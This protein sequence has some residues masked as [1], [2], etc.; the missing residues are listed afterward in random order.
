MAL[1][2]GG[3]E[4]PRAVGGLV[5]PCGVAGDQPGFHGL[6]RRRVQRGQALLAALAADDQPGRI[7]AHRLQPQAQQF[8]HPKTRRIGQL[9]QGHEPQAGGALVRRRGEQS[10]D[11][12]AR[13]GPGQ[14]AALF[15]SIQSPRRIVAAPAFAQCEPVELAH[16]RPP[17]GLG[18]RRQALA[19]QPGVPAF[20]PRL[21][22]LHQP[23]LNA[24]LGVG[25]IAAVGGK[26]MGRG[27]AF[28]GHHLQKGFDLGRAHASRRFL[29]AALGVE[30]EP[31]MPCL[32]TP[33]PSPSR[34]LPRGR[35]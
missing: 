19:R 6:A 14:A 23:A 3:R 25:Q 10:L 16:R 11:L 17:P 32:P 9:D 34:H 28:D 4:Q 26:G 8:G 20:D 15:R 27:V 33:L 13:Q 29:I 22:A 24:R 18:G 35:A 7:A 12:L 2:R 30:D 21:V 5:R 1:R 31:V